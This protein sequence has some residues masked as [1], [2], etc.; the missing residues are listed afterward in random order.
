MLELRE[1]IRSATFDS[2]P[3]LVLG[4]GPT[5]SRRSDFD[6]SKYQLLSLNHVVRE[7]PVD[8]AHVIDIDVVEDCASE[9]LHN[10]QWLVMPRVPHIHQRPGPVRL[11]DYFDAVPVLE[12]ID[13]K[14]RLV[15]YNAATAPPVGDSPVIDVTYFSSEAALSL[16]GELGVRVVRSLGIDGGVSYSASFS[17]LASRTRLANRQP[18]FDLQFAEIERIA[19]RYG[20]DY[21]PLVSPLRIY[22]GA[23]RRD[24]LAVRVLEYSIRK[25]ATIPVR[26]VPM[27]DLPVPRARRAVNRPRTGFSFSRFLIPSLAGYKGRAVYL[28]SD[29]LVFGDVAEL[30]S[31]PF[32]EKKVLSTYQ[33]V[34]PPEWRDN[35]GFHPGRHSAVMVMDCSQLTWDIT[36]IVQDLDAGRLTYEELMAGL[37][38]EDDEFGI[39]PTEWNHLERYEPGVT[40]LL[41]Y[42]VVNSQPWRAPGNPLEKVWLEH[43]REAVEAGVVPPDE[44]EDLVAEGFVRSDLL[45][46]LV[47]IPVRSRAHSS[48]A[49]VALAGAFDRIDDLKASQLRAR[50][51]R[52]ARHA[53]S[54]LI[55]RARAL[56]PTGRL[57]TAIDR[58]PAPIR[59]RLR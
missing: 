44:M 29:M 23:S 58:L 51:R 52:G 2:R 14:G 16:L 32:N 10:C 21:A 39:L 3:W 45:G 38:L 15:W 25:N 20:I 41:H 24:L 7:L 8:V 9:L 11:E 19:K 49:S 47:R 37:T 5:F 48:A 6:L 56:I 40:K 27:V 4:K 35:P 1:W 26:I 43:Y 57:A 46:D 50:L 28:D 13:R 53:L 36:E 42:T 30:E 18:S 34:P 31:Y 12:E 59:S 54:P 22:I 17:S 33:E 55:R